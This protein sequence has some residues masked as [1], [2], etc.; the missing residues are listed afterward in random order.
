MF[1]SRRIPQAL[2]SSLSSTTS[3]LLILELSSASYIINQPYPI[4]Q[5][6]NETFKFFL[7]VYFL[8]DDWKKN[9]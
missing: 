7:I 3:F 6:T 9:S 1:S 2:S 5:L 8:V 4:N